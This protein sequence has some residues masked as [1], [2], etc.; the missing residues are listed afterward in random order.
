MLLIL[1]H[2]LDNILNEASTPVRQN[3]RQCEVRAKELDFGAQDKLVPAGAFVFIVT[4]LMKWQRI[5]V[6]LVE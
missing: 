6:Q 5:F 3:N 2:H 4:A 1:L